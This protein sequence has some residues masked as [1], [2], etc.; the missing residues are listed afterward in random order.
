LLIITLIGFSLAGYSQA[1]VTTNPAN[2]ISVTSAKMNGYIDPGAGGECYSVKFEYSTASDLSGSTS[3]VPDQGDEI[4]SATSLTYTLTGLT[5]NTKYYFRLKV[6]YSTADHGAVIGGTLDFTTSTIQKPTIETGTTLV[7]ITTTS[8]DVNGNDASDDGGSS[9][10]DKGVCFGTSAN[11]TTET[12]DGSTGTGTYNVSKTGANPNVRY[13]ARAYAE[14]SKGTSYGANRNFKTMPGTPTSDAADAITATTFKAHWTNGDGGASGITYKLYISKQSDFSSYIDGY[15]PKAV[16]ADIERTVTD[17]EV[18]T[19][20]YYRVVAI[21][22]GGDDA[23]DNETPV[24]N[25][26]SVTTGAAGLPVELISFT[27]TLEQESVYLAWTTAS[28]INNDYFEL[29][30]SFD[31]QNYNTIG[32]VEGSGNSNIIVNYSISDNESYKGVAFYR[33]KQV[34]Y[35]GQHEYSEIIA[36]K[37]ASDIVLSLIDY[38]YDGGHIKMNINN[39]NN[40][41]LNVNVMDIS[42]KIVKSADLKSLS[43]LQFSVNDLSRGVYI[44]NIVSETD[45]IVKKIIL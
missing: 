40:E 43:N 10:T 41:T 31:N 17:L 8:G 21:N 5:G 12:S 24:S 38:T 9:I 20:Y 30:R 37:K 11:P 6:G 23:P 39:P 32:K 19:D 45:I 33:L 7:N 35:D 18:A 25:T 4:L 22:D 44:I 14:N 15:G 27:A 26:T 34:D 2:T 42:G 29:Q 16:D 1:T 36:V 3:V 28:E 13:Y